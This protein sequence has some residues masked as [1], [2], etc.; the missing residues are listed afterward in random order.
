MLNT[1]TLNILILV[2]VLSVLA[3]V[4]CYFNTEKT[5][6]VGE[7]NLLL[8]ELNTYKVS[9][10]VVKDHDNKYTFYKDNDTWRI[11][12]KNGYPVIPDRIEEIL[13]GL[14]DLRI[15]EPK[16]TNPEYYPIL[17]VNPVHDQ[18][19]KAIELIATDE[20][21]IEQVH[22]I[23]GKREE[24]KVFVRRPEEM[25]AW[26]VLGFLDLSSDF[27]DWVK[28]PLLGLADEDQVSKVEIVQPTG[29]QLVIAKESIDAEDFQVTGL[30]PQ[31]Q[32]ALD[33]D[34]I[35][36]LPYALAEIEYIDV[37]PATSM[38]IDWDKSLL[39]SLTTFNGKTT[40]LKLKK[41]SGQIFAMVDDNS[42]W[43][44][45]VPDHT[46]ALVAVDKT[47]FVMPQPSV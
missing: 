38:D 15:L 10:L 4:Y 40:R 39:V 22:L 19:S 16:T 44:F 6:G 14:A 43:C 32:E 24:L 3:L 33:L 46:Y 2:T 29:E 27:R 5:L 26:L 20:N 8:P 13:Y 42:D 21:G 18:D 28:Q 7:N 41:F 25:Q 34:A 47:D 12:E 30:V 37:M 36:S 9:K 11:L 31:Q 35:N 17:G 1:R 23:I 45:R